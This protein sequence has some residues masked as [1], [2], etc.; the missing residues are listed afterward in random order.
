MK[1]MIDIIVTK[2]IDTLLTCPQNLLKHCNIILMSS[3]GL[4]RAR[5]GYNHDMVW[6]NSMLNRLTMI[7]LRMR[8]ELKTG[9]LIWDETEIDLSVSNKFAKESHTIHTIYIYIY[10]S[11]GACLT[12]VVQSSPL[13]LLDGVI[14]LELRFAGYSWVIVLNKKSILRNI[15]WFYDVFTYQ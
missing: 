8:T 3:M 6:Y 5:S 2:T 10:I 13:W 14:Y 11:P 9:C 1:E 4:I 7:I 12:N 15:L